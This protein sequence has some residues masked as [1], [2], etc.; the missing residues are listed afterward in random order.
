MA[1]TEFG[2]RSTFNEGSVSSIRAPEIYTS[3]Q[4]WLPFEGIQ[5]WI[6]FKGNQGHVHVYISGAPIQ[7]CLL[8]LEVLCKALCF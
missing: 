6:P 2:F 7:T 4:P 1:I 5:A 3:T 8:G